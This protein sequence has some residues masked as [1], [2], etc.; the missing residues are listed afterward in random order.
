M[1]V[2][3]HEIEFARDVADKIIFMDDGVIAEEGTPDHVIGNP[4]N[5]RTQAFLSRFNQY[6]K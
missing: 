6:A 3:T 5:P 4:K 1:I 2:V